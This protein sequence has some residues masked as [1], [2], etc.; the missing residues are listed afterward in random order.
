MCLIDV[1][2]THALMKSPALSESSALQH[3]KLSDAFE[4]H[5]RILD[6]YLGLQHI[7]VVALI[8]FSLF[9]KKDPSYSLLPLQADNDPS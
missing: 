7:Q 9:M 6:F 4:I 1:S 8:S 2:D 3:V 5:D